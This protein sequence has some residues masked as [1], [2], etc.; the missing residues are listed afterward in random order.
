MANWKRI[1]KLRDHL[2]ALKQTKDRKFDMN[3]WIA[4]LEKDSKNT[5]TVGELRKNG[6]TC[7]SAACLAGEAVIR[8]APINGVVTGLLDGWYVKVADANGSSEITQVARQ[9]LGLTLDE[10]EYMFGGEWGCGDGG[11]LSAITKAQAVR[12]LTKAL[13]AKNVMVCLGR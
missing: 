11:S 2:R 7:G 10:A 8:F 6:P 1:E 5:A 13:K 9:L 12:Y 4:S 3:L